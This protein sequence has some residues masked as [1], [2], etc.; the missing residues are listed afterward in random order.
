MEREVVIVSSVRTPFGRFGGKLK[1]LPLEELGAYAVKEV[2]N[3][4]NVSGDMIEELYMGNCNITEAEAPSVIG[5]QVALR[6]GLPDRLFSLT[7][8]AAC[9]SSLVGARLCY[10]A[11]KLG[12]CD[13]ALAAGVESMSRTGLII[14]YTVRWG[15]KFGHVVAYDWYFGL[16][17]P[18]YKAASADTGD[19]ALEYGEGRE[20]QDAWGYRSQ[21]RYAEALKDGKF[22]IGGELMAVEVPQKKG[23]SL[24]VEK[25]EQPRPDTSME[26][27]G[28]LKPVYGSATV[29]AG[30]A[31]GL[32][33]GASAVLIMSREKADELGLEIQAKIIAGA[34]FS[35]KPR[36]MAAVPGFAIQNVLKRAGMTIDDIDLIQVNE[37][38][39]AMP[40][41]AT[42][43]LADGDEKKLAVLRDI[44]NV[45]GDA[46]AIGH[47]VGASG[48]RIL[49]TA[50]RELK[51]RGGGKA[52]V[53]LCG[54]LSQGEAM[55]VEV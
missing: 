31:P 45:N 35:G 41:I 34:G 22:D 3:R 40:L 27:L 49:M 52:V 12:E 48:C 37:A 32:N 36:E 14:P 17:Y 7:L 44:T 43:I 23:P 21:M 47:P 19:V 1:D 25:D 39:A 20:E 5:R 26:K 33:D 9:T 55:I 11:I 24:R 2:L 53:S 51:R 13:I 50:V 38:F 29:T 8:D 28:K 16:V 30:N 18:G 4:V 15:T 10:R 46:V 54:G 42:R 6:A